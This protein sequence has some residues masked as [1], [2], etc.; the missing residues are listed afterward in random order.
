MTNVID[1]ETILRNNPDLDAL[2]DRFAEI[3]LPDAWIVA[4]SLAQ[5]VWNHRFG[6]AAKHGIGDIDLV[7]FDPDLTE[8]TEEAHAQRLPA[9]F[10]EL[11]A[12][13]DVKNQARVHQWYGEKF[14][15]PL[16]PY[17]STPN[18]IATYPTTATSVGIRRLDGQTEICAPFGLADLFAGIVRPNKALVTETVYAAKATR[19]RAAWPGLTII[20]WDAA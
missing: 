14:G 10:P 2:L 3:A 8:A 11:S 13:L 12:W 4:G 18:A 15:R 1:L 6:L 17:T 9:L 20:P 19:W 16:T 5:T 7:Y